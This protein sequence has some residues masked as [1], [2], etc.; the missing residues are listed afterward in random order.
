MS[1]IADQ[2]AQKTYQELDRLKKI[3]KQPKSRSRMWQSPRGYRFLVQWTNAVLLRILIRKLTKSF[4]RSEYRTKTQLDDAARSVV[5]NLEE[6]YKRPT[7]SE[8]L[9][10][11]GYS[12]GSLEEVHGDIN[13]CLQ[14]EFLISKKGSSLKDLGINL[15]SWN[16][17]ARN[18]INS[19]KI[20]YFP[21]EKNRGGYRNLKEIKGKNITYEM[22]VELVN[23]TDYLLRQLVKS[24][25][26]K[27]NQNRKGYQIEK[28]RIRGNLK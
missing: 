8:Y 11:I 2:L 24:L 4:P 12:Q 3:E 27:L 21:L 17:W 23:K 6:G 15:K 7:T 5:S 9:N 26:S 28:A 19:S 10:F 14:D 18:P 16:Q 20:L 1:K 25:E 13:K 22:L